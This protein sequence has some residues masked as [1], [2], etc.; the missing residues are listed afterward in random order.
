MRN[1]LLAPSNV[2]STTY[3]KDI[4]AVVSQSSDLDQVAQQSDDRPRH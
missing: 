1:L 2:L 3:R 4:E